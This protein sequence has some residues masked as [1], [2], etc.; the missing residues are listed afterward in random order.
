MKKYIPYN[1]RN[2]NDTSTKPP[3]SQTYTTPNHNETKTNKDAT[4]ST[5][6]TTSR[7][8]KIETDTNDDMYDTFPS[9][10]WD[11]VKDE[12]E[13]SS[14]QDI[15]DTTSCINVVLSSDATVASEFPVSVGD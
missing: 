3:N 10:I 1:K 5:S 8:N 13:L 4:K 9:F 11:L 14:Q 15:G 12:E 2:Q 7:V 6:T